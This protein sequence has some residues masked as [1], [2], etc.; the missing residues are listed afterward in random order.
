VDRIDAAEWFTILDRATN[1]EL[2][3]RLVAACQRLL[4]S[5]PTHPGLHVLVGLGMLRQHQ[6]DLGAASSHVQAA[7][8]N[9]VSEY[10]ASKTDLTNVAQC[11]FRANLKSLDALT[12]ESV[13]ARLV[14][15][16]KSD[17]ISRAAYPFATSRELRRKCSV[18]WL[19]NIKLRSRMIRETMVESA[20]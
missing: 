4:E 18:P 20:Q 19:R 14:I 6:F 5:Y 13:L 1:T 3:R 8:Q 7:F 9:F 15:D 17:L 2:A 10:G 16:S 11:I 12:A